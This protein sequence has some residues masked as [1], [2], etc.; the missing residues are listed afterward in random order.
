M[1]QLTDIGGRTTD[2]GIFTISST[3]VVRLDAEEVQPRGIQTVIHRT[4]C[5]LPNL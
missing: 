4:R 1:F 5:Q 2:S 3:D